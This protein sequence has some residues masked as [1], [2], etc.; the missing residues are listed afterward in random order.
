MGSGAFLDY[1]GVFD[2]SSR[3]A[4]IRIFEAITIA[5]HRKQ[6]LPIRSP[7][8]IFLKPSFYYVELFIAILQS[9]FL[10]IYSGPEFH[11]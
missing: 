7:I 1:I 10:D 6:Y 2:V 9:G 8:P 3:G 4:P 11:F 5:D